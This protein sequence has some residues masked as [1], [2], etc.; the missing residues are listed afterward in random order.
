M[1]LNA[2]P[3]RSQLRREFRWNQFPNQ[4][5]KNQLRR[6]LINF[7]SQEKPSKFNSAVK[8]CILVFAYIYPLFF[9]DVQYL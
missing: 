8:L 5:S 4:F 9:H 7:N 1:N 6:E 3:Q 2:I